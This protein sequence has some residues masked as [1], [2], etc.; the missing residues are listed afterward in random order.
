MSAATGQPALDRHALQVAAGSLLD[1][2]GVQSDKAT[3][4]AREVI[5]AY[6]LAN[7]LKRNANPQISPETK[8]LMAMQI[9]EVQ[10]FGGIG[11]QGLNERM[12]TARGIMG[13]NARWSIRMHPNGDWVVRRIGDGQ[14][15]SK[16]L[17]E[18]EKGHLLAA[19][20]PGESAYLPGFGGRQSLRAYNKNAARLILGDMH[21]NWTGRMTSRGRRITRIK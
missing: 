12:K 6:L 18:N 10:D 5:R 16:T 15:P 1:H 14:R 21:A 4:M 2:W 19:L 20:A 3:P 8:R 9:G 7:R 17:W 13:V 11:Y